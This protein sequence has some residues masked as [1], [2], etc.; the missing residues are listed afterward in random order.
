MEALHALGVALLALLVY[1]VW[2][3]V[4]FRGRAAFSADLPREVPQMRDGNLPIF[5]T[6]FR[7]A[8]VRSLLYDEILRWSEELGPVFRVTGY[9][10]F[11]AFMDALVAVHPKDVEHVLRDPYV[12][13]K[14][15][16]FREAFGTLF[17]AGIFAADG[18]HWRVLRKTASN[19]FS[20]RSFRDAYTPAFAAD[21]AVLRGHLARAAARG[22]Q[23]PQA[24]VD[25]QDLLLRSTM[26]SFVRISMGADVGN[27]AGEGTFDASGRYVLPDVPF[28]KALDGMNTV[29][30]A[31]MD[32][33]FWKVTEH[34][35]GTRRKLRE[36]N[37]VLDDFTGRIIAEKRARRAKGEVG[38][39]DLL[40][41]YLDHK[42]EDGS[43]LPD[44]VLRDAA[45]NMILAGRDTT[46][47]TLAWLVYELDLHPG[48]ADLARKEMDAVLGPD[49][50][51]LPGYAE[52]PEL[53]Y[54]MAVFLETLRLHSNVPAN[55]KF[56]AKDSVL[57]ATGA[58]VKAGQ[59]VILSSYAMG[60]SELVWGADRLEFKP[61]RW[62]DEKGGL[63]R[64][65]SYKYP[66]F[67]AGPRICLGMDM[68]KQEAM[69]LM[70]AM[71]RRFRLEVVRE[72]DPAKWGDFAAR[73][74]RYDIQVTLALR[75]AL[76]VRVVE[77]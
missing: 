77:V 10:P 43:E 19:I 24:C 53:R 68:A 70:C 51:R 73:R 33:P 49:R 28:S 20:V 52:I 42:Q 21:A 27:L 72:D 3:A 46:A 30:R 6:I 7:V 67:N 59:A 36:W 76:D 65:D 1:T 56:V 69:V 63:K 38:R 23:D 32:Q 9:V 4:R 61:E 45:R 44:H 18:N 60:R 13:E 29:C 34:L 39:N 17:G 64:E 14:G 15:D 62:L 47:Q 50:D 40:D 12:F 25:V 41:F 35:D 22:K 2:L 58:P 31:R 55:I 37:A 8:A 54:C 75:K 26:D 74:G 5:G 57:P 71:L 48:C 11:V 16:G 66:A